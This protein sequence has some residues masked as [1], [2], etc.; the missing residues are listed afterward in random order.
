MEPLGRQFRRHRGDGDLRVALL[1]LLAAWSFT[2]SG[3]L[4]ANQPCVSDIFSVPPA[5]LKVPAFTDTVQLSVCVAQLCPSTVVNATQ[6]TYTIIVQR[7]NGVVGQAFQP[8]ALEVGSTGTINITD[9]EAGVEYIISAQWVLNGTIMSN[10]SMGTFFRVPANTTAPPG[11]AP[12]DLRVATRST[13]SFTLAYLP[14]L[15]P[16]NVISH[17][18]IFISNGSNAEV[19]NTTALTF[20]L[21]DLMPNTLYFITVSASN[22][23]NPSMFG[24]ETPALQAS[25]NAQAQQGD[26]PILIYLLNNDL[27]AGTTPAGNRLNNVPA[28]AH[29]MVVTDW[30]YVYDPLG[31]RGNQRTLFVAEMNQITS[32]TTIVSVQGLILDEIDLPDF[33]LPVRFTALTLQ[34]ALIDLPYTVTSL[35]YDWINRRL[36]LGAWNATTG[37][38]MITVATAVDMLADF[39]M[40]MPALF[41]DGLTT[42]VTD[43]GLDPMDG[44]LYFTLN[45]TGQMMRVDIGNPASAIPI[46][47]GYQIPT[48]QMFLEEQTLLFQTNRSIFLYSLLTG[49]VTQNA[50]VS[51]INNSREFAAYNNFVTWLHSTDDDASTRGDIFGNSIGDSTIPVNGRSTQLRLIRSGLQPRP[52]SSNPIQNLQVLV[53]ATAARITWLP[54]SIATVG[55]GAFAVWSYR[56][57][58]TP[59]TSQS[60]PSLCRTVVFD[61]VMPSVDVAL[62]ATLEPATRYRFQVYPYDNVLFANS[63][64]CAS[65]VDGRYG[66][67]SQAVEVFT[68]AA[69]NAESA[70]IVTDPQGYTIQYSGVSGLPR[71]QLASL[72]I[73]PAAVGFDIEN[74]SLI[75][76]QDASSLVTFTRQANSL[77]SFF[78]NPPP[79]SELP[80]SVMETSEQVVGFP[81]VGAVNTVRMAV[82]YLGKRIF[83]TLGADIYYAHYNTPSTS[84]R[85]MAAAGT[86]VD[87]TLDVSN[88]HIYWV[89]P[90]TFH[91]GRMN[92]NYCQSSRDV[93]ILV[94]RPNALIPGETLKAVQYDVTTDRLYYTLEIGT[95][96]VLKYGTPMPLIGHLVSLVTVFSSSLPIAP[97]SPFDSKVYYRTP[98]AAGS[99]SV[100]DTQLSN[101]VPPYFASF[102]A[103]DGALLS[104]VRVIAEN[105]QPFNACFVDLP[106]DARPSTPSNLVVNMAMSNSSRLVL[107]WDA[108]TPLCDGSPITYN[109]VYRT[110]AHGTGFPVLAEL[111]C[112]VTLTDAS[113]ITVDGLLPATRLEVVSLQA[114]STYLPSAIVADEFFSADAAPVGAPL[115]T[116]VFYSC[117]DKLCDI[118][119]R[120]NAIA[121]DQQNGNITSYTVRLSGPS[122]QTVPGI[123]I[124]S[125][126]FSSL[127]AGGTYLLEVLGVNS[128]GQGPFSSSATVTLQALGGVFV[129]EILT[130]SGSAP[131]SITVFDVDRLEASAQPVVRTPDIIGGPSPEQYS[132]TFIQF[133]SRSN[134]TFWVA[135]IGQSTWALRYQSSDGV[136]C[137]LR[138]EP[139]AFDNRAVVGLSFDWIG[140]V[141]YTIEQRG[142][143]YSVYQV[144]LPVGDVCQA[145]TLQG[146]ILFSTTG[147]VLNSLNYSP[148]SGTLFYLSGDSIVQMTVGEQSATSPPT[149]AASA[150]RRRRQISVQSVLTSDGVTAIH[151]SAVEDRTYIAVSSSGVTV[152]RCPNL[153]AATAQ[154][155]CALYQ[156]GHAMSASIDSLYSDNTLLYWTLAGVTSTIYYQRIDQLASTS[157]FMST[158]RSP[159]S[160]IVAFGTQLQPVPSLACLRPPVSDL[161]RMP[162]TVL[163]VTQTTVDILAPTPV[164]TS[165]CRALTASLAPSRVAV[166]VQPENG[167]TFTVLSDSPSVRIPGLSPFT[168]HNITVMSYENSWGTTANT[169]AQPAVVTTLTGLPP[170]T[171]GVRRTVLLP[172]TILVEWDAPAPGTSTNGIITHYRAEATLVSSAS[173]SDDPV[174]VNSTVLNATI[175]SLTPGAM[176]SITVFS[177]TSAGEGPGSTPVTAT[178]LPSPGSIAVE[179]PQPGTAI[180]NCVNVGS[181]P[182]SDVLVTCQSRPLCSSDMTCSGAAVPVVVPVNSSRYMFSSLEGGVIYSTTV[183]YTYPSGDVYTAT[184]QPTLVAQGTRPDAPTDLRV[185]STTSGTFEYSWRAPLCRRDSSQIPSYML[186]ITTVSGAMV[187]INTTGSP[188]QDNRLGAEA[189]EDAS[190]RFVVV[191]ARNSLG[192]SG[193][194]NV[195]QITNLTAVGNEGDGGSDNLP[196]IIGVA[197]GG[198]VLLIL[199]IVVTIVVY[200]RQSEKDGLLPPPFIIPNGN[201]ANVINDFYATDRV[202]LDES[203]KAYEIDASLI[204]LGDIL[205]KGHFGVVNKGVYRPLNNEEPRVVA[206]KSSASREGDNEFL[207]EAEIMLDMNDPHILRCY[208]L[209][210]QPRVWLV[211]EYCD[212]GNLLS[213][214]EACKHQM[215]GGVVLSVLDVVNMMEDIARGMVYLEQQHKVHRDLAARNILIANNPMSPERK[216]KISDFGLTRDNY[217][218]EY[219]MDLTQRDKALPVRWVA[220][221]CMTQ[222][223]F[224]SK[225]DVWAFGVVCWELGSLGDTPYGNFRSARDIVNEVKRGLKIQRPPYF[226]DEMYRIMLAAMHYRPE[227]RANF[228]QLVTMIMHYK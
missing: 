87:L 197:A 157:A 160:P 185:V 225:S 23:N 69:S 170:A 183:R 15:M 128:A 107:Q 85:F 212:G 139:S 202:E 188:T 24:P 57:D 22:I 133:D 106:A 145:S 5:P 164:L 155:N 55:T 228:T 222:G 48:F 82:D 46:L 6:V 16:S 105:L 98:D 162:P 44:Y 35:V 130:T 147:S 94:P 149:T 115:D 210:V 25:T 19:F 2:A 113:S 195:V 120:W 223:I 53:S 101:V 100:V 36:Y 11:S 161:T 93:A 224:N 172:D 45:V 97:I 1:A 123:R 102:R 108:S 151:Y 18:Q 9:V 127:L 141:L 206:V 63:D 64:P 59:V 169:G 37:I 201:G 166:R 124:Q 58:I 52:I 91:V 96:T 54:P 198:G 74:G 175:T 187:T 78:S 17:Y 26:I 83:W 153:T 131:G 62:N 68:L 109:L 12:V 39:N 125:H 41:V 152:F 89:S 159:D 204:E 218:E 205:G 50:L 28:P 176:Y 219:V 84:V 112:P 142:T 33:T 65:G 189:P 215:E 171:P 47:N 178:T 140:R 99:V 86:V 137:T 21:N 138:T 167:S 217:T 203:L 181:V 72:M 220:P 80:T 43:M 92:T 13:T 136:V 77:V 61:A 8:V 116:R 146:T 143:N 193:P 150:K 132:V 191:L 70:I 129:P 119:F 29:G 194:S 10:L 30:N 216:L 27:R 122:D 3:V 56:V 214:L 182:C 81:A 7:D 227:R 158:S 117:G 163:A 79:G 144:R 20:T 95:Q 196:L 31:G 34:D 177:S 190:Y 90:N 135:A 226:T 110:T 104:D 192:L 4:A 111:L 184:Q 60:A 121:L 213:F 103:A 165:E 179:M 211:M 209:C 126:T 67:G 180:V 75:Y 14:P 174:S 200:R 76:A 156:P 168:V 32:L 40:T 134:E 148:K 221:E 114:F 208:G 66:S 49:V 199:L 38:G 186:E 71:L 118:E 154:S 207:L 73:P 173:V 42:E 51:G 88:G